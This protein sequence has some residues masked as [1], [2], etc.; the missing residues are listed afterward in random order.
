ML[1]LLTEAV[2]DSLRRLDTVHGLL[3]V[4]R[5]LLAALLDNHVQHTE[6]WLRYK[7]VVEGRRVFDR[8]PVLDAQKVLCLVTGKGQAA[9]DLAIVNGW[10]LA[11]P[12][13]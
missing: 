4:V 11:L 9:R 8:N 13:P 10:L 1:L 6:L 5:V 3:H 2:H 7:Y 12:L